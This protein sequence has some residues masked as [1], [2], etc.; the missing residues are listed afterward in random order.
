MDKIQNTMEQKFDHLI[1]KHNTERQAV[2]EMLYAAADKLQAGDPVLIAIGNA[3]QHLQAITP[4]TPIAPNS[5]E[6]K[7]ESAA[8]RDVLAERK[9][10]I[11][12]KGWTAEHDD[13]HN[14]GQMAMAAAY[15]AAHTVNT[16]HMP[17]YVKEAINGMLSFC[18][19]WSRKW[20]KP[21]TPRRNLV[22]AGAL[23]IAEIERIDRATEKEK[24]S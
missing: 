2:L 18:W 19:P 15:Y 5:A 7:A 21:S 16:N 12:V 8:I 23:I 14:D 1:D 17:Q 22:K 11:S 4:P 6:L 20:W 3:I 10:Q 13:T 24:Q 9:R